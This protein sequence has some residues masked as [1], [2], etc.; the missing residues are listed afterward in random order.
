MLV[1]ERRRTSAL[2]VLISLGCSWLPACAATATHVRGPDGESDWYNIDCK[3]DQG[4]CYAEAGDVCPLGYVTAYSQGHSGTV[5][6]ANIDASGGNASAV[7]TYR[8]NMLIK[9]KTD[10][11]AGRDD[12]SASD[13]MAAAKRSYAQC[14]HAYAD[15]RGMA[16]TWSE[17]FGGDAS[18]APPEEKA[19]LQLCGTLSEAARVCLGAEHARTHREDCIAAIRVLPSETRHALDDFLVTR[20]STK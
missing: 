14:A 2:L 12:E 4:A 1:I 18:E 8:G 10:A 20:E 11:A 19:F 17:W 5:L 15:E 7:P 9:C 3:H 6:V 13:P 16:E